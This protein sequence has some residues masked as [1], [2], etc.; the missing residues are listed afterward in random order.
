MNHDFT[1]CSWKLQDNVLPAKLARVG[2]E[3]SAMLILVYGS[4]VEI[5]QTLSP[6]P[7]YLIFRVLSNAVHLF[8]QLFF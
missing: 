3:R 7:L 4:P 5:F 8:S 6:K 1:A 2:F